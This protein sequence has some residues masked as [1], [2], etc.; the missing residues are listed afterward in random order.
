MTIINCVC[1]SYFH[2]F[3]KCSGKVDQQYFCINWWRKVT[4]HKYQQYFWAD[5]GQT[6]TIFHVFSEHTHWT[7][8]RWKKEVKLFKWLQL[9]SGLW[10]WHTSGN[11][12]STVVPLL[13]FFFKNMSVRWFGPPMVFLLNNGLFDLCVILSASCW[14]IQWTTIKC[15]YNSRNHLQTFHILDLWQNNEGKGHWLP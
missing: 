8:W 7:E 10:R 4:N 3:G 6:L 12:L 14:V 13:S 9:R 2:S 15:T 5:L 1:Y 11:C